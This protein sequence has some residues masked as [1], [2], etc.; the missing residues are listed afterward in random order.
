[1]ARWA[2]KSRLTMT[3]SYQV[4][5]LSCGERNV[6]V[7]RPH[8][9]S[10]ADR[11]VGHLR[12]IDVARSGRDHLVQE[13]DGVAG[14]GDVVDVESDFLRP[15]GAV[16]ER[17]RDARS[18]SGHGPEEAPPDDGLA[19]VPRRERY[20]RLRVGVTADAGLRVAVVPVGGLGEAGRD[21]AVERRDA[22]DGARERIEGGGVEDVREARDH[23]VGPEPE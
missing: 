12:R 1:M 6:S 9:W 3:M 17:R 20:H 11:D 4:G 10:G 14:V 23:H 13:R 21:G 22:D 16:G 8:E 7:D 2:F 18:G 5:R 15:S 19:G